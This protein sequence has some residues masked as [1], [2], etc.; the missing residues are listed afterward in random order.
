LPRLLEVTAL[1]DIIVYVASDERYNDEVPTQYLH[2]MLQTGKPVVVCLTKMRESD[3][4]ALVTHFQREVLSKLPP[5][6]I[7][8]LTIPHLTAAQLADPVHE[9][10]RYRIP[11]LNQVGVLGSPAAAA[12]RRSVRTATNFLINDQERLLAAAQADV[13]ALESW[14]DTVQNGQVEFNNRY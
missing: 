4:P 2:M 5:G 7:G 12:R 14:R 8:C 1:A 11:L 9:T 10:A 13:K 3:A 6:V